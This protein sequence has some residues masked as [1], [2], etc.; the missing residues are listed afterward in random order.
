[1]HKRQILFDEVSYCYIQ[2]CDRVEVYYRNLARQ[3]YVSFETQTRAAIG[4]EALSV[5]D[6][7]RYK[8]RFY[9]L[10]IVDEQLCRAGVESIDGLALRQRVDAMHV[11]CEHAL[12]C[13]VACLPENVIELHN[14]KHAAWLSRY[15]SSRHK[16]LRRQFRQ[17]IDELQYRYDD[18]ARKYD[19]GTN[20]FEYLAKLLVERMEGVFP[21]VVMR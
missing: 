6:F 2:A 21:H 18:V 20:E 10:M 13:A 4:D 5:L 15:R 11:E 14:I 9:D 16:L 8:N 1:M 7:A 3:L 19:T 17:C 12:L